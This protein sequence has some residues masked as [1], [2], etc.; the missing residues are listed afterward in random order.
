MEKQREVF[1]LFKST[2]ILLLITMLMAG[3]GSISDGEYTASV[4]LTG[5]SGKAYIVSPCKIT[6]LNGKVT[7]DIFWS[8]KNY[9]YMIVGGKTYYP[10]NTDGT[11]EFVI[12]IELDKDMSVQADTVAM[13]TP[14]LIDYT[15]RF[16]LLSGDENE[17]ENEAGDETSGKNTKDDNDTLSVSDDV[18]APEIPGISFISTDENEYASC[19]AIHRYS[20]DF[21]VICVDDGRKYLLIPENAD[22]DPSDLKNLIPLKKPLNRIYL[23][24]SIYQS[25]RSR[26]DNMI[27]SIEDIASNWHITP[28]AAR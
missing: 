15:L 2:V 8:S 21:A 10:V 7:A 4:A 19:F 17:S 5:G 14:H 16:S 22:I 25:S 1:L 6:V 13:S 18:S 3:C 24:A 26:P 23:A 27:S 20:E 11:S 28:D 12:P 9:D